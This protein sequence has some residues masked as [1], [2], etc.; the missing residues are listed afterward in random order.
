MKTLFTLVAPGAVTLTGAGMLLLFMPTN[1]LL[2]QA[3]RGYPLVALAV[4]VLLAWRMHRSRVLLA[5][6]LLLGAHGALHESALGGEPAASTLAAVL[7]PLLIGALAFSSD[8]NV[9]GRH[10]ALQ[11]LA[12]LLVIGA[13]AAA[14]IAAPVEA[15][16]LLTYRFIDPIYTSWTGLEQVAIVATLLGLFDLTAIALIR[17]KAM[18]AGL[19][20][21]ALAGVLA[22]AAPQSSMARGVWLLAAGLILI[23]T[24]V[25][26]SYM[27][28]FHDEL[29]G[30]P[31][32]R[33]LSQTLGALRPPY[34][35]AIVDV[36]HFKSFNDRYGHDVGDEVLR[37]VA[38]RLAAVTGGGRAYRSGGEEFTIVFPGKTKAE[39][40]PHVEQVREAVEG[41]KFTL[42]RQPRP[43]KKVGESR[44]GAR[45]G[46][47]RRIGVT[48]SVG[49]AGVDVRNPTTDAVV[50]AADKAMYRAKKKGR[51]RVVA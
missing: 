4:A 8:R 19:G 31:A 2:V 7:L 32:R 42:R 41:A 17:G 27:M 13:G 21:A 16:L 35:V 20:W 3:S 34:T 11:T 26:S 46:N 15:E 39:A 14:L 43:S 49:L 22:I 47:E 10:V 9:A 18:D 38:T 36:D 40:L 29:T 6:L 25:E 48:I 44:R 37:M 33:V 30:L 12:M 1:E 23:I 45:N 28:A 51:N 5:G 50:K 24:L